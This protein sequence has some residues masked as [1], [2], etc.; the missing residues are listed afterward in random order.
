ML[1][2]VVPDC[3]PF[4]GGR[5]GKRKPAMHDVT[6][7][8]LMISRDE[9]ATVSQDATLRDAVIALDDAQKH[10]DGEQFKHR[11]VLVYNEKNRV[12]GKVSQWDVIRALEP[13]Y[14]S[15]S[16]FKRLTRFGLSDDYIQSMFKDFELW[17]TP[18]ESLYAK[19][20]ALK[21]K[22]IMYTP[23]KA[24]YVKVDTSLEEAVHQLIVGHHQSLLVVENERVVGILRIV[25]VFQEVCSRIKEC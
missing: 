7:K 13:T 11:A 25:D 16:G 8:D 6:V 1:L 12:V 2:V 23:D 22:D 9:Y 4:C 18:L 5:P 17:Q 24:E 14:D 3:G 21:V 20:S 19:T 10:L 15:I